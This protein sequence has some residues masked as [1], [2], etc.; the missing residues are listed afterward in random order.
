MGHE[1]HTVVKDVGEMPN[2]VIL[3][4]IREIIKLKN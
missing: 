1:L 3:E 4:K 2:S